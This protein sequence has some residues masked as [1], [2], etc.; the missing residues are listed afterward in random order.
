MLKVCI[1]Q[2]GDVVTVKRNFAYNKLLV[3][4]LGD[5]VTPEALEKS[6]LIRE[7]AK[8]VESFS[9]LSA[10]QTV[11]YLESQVLSVV[12]NKE[13]EWTIEPWHIRVS[14]RKA[15]IHVPDACISLPAKPIY[16]PDAEL[17][18]KEFCV[19]V[20]INNKEKAKVRCR[21]HHWSTNPADRL[22][23]ID[24][25]WLKESEPIF[26][27]EADI[28]KKLSHQSSLNKKKN[29]LTHS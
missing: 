26:P 27:E 1:G 16:G 7:K 6:K 23:H 9:S 10:L 8:E 21:I 14:F 12:M 25:Y 3:P 22:P 13:T 29:E 24:H 18:S 4:G 17:E 19:T 28:L 5:Y 15:G 11:R 2:R 20:T